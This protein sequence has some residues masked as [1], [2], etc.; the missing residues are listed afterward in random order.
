MET[1]KE[2]INCKQQKSLSEFALCKTCV[3]GHVNQCK[4]C[5]NLRRS[6][7]RKSS[8]KWKQTNK[9]YKDKNRDKSNAWSRIYTLTYPEKRKRNY[10]KYIRD[11]PDKVKMSQKAWLK[12]NPTYKNDYSVA[13][14][15]IDVEYRIKRSLRGRIQSAMMLQKA[16]KMH[17]TLNL[18]GCSVAELKIH[19]ES[20]FLPTM[21]WENYGSVWHIDHIIPCSNFNLLNKDDQYRCFHYSNL[22]PLFAVTTIIDNV[23][24]IGNYNKGAKV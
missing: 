12:R 10:Q 19:L 23:T 5:I 15:K 11:N 13:R 22:Q 4:D 24:Y 7:Y 18:L 3:D 8:Q 6:L 9:L 20:K 16:Q 2:C 14:A 17:R 1:K 21:S